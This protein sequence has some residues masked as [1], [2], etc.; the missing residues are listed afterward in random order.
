MGKGIVDLAVLYPSGKLGQARDLVDTLGF[1][2]QQTPD[3][4]PEERPMRV[5]AVAHYGYTFQLHIHILSA[6][7]GEVGELL[8]FRNRLRSEPGLREAYV[9]RKRAIIDA[10][11]GD[12][13]E[14]CYAKGNFVEEALGRHGPPER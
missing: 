10:G 8:S 3:P 7:C 13:L 11:V 12:P 5:G 4:F 6:D 2:R 1:Q 14:Y 9:A